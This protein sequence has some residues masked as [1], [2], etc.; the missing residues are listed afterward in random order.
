MTKEN[1]DQMTV[2]LSMTVL[3]QANGQYACQM[4]SSLGD[5][6]ED[7]QCYGQTQEHA[8]AIALEQL[9]GKYR[10]MAEEQQN[11]EWDV[12]ERTETGKPIE[13]QYH[14]VLHYEAIMKAESKFWAKYDVI[15][16]NTVVENAKVIVIEIANDLPT[17]SLM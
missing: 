7:I 14:V 1:A 12:V 5:D 2:T 3:P 15:V 16:G 8:I 10:E 17:E 6:E 13:K 9:A 11:I 4:S